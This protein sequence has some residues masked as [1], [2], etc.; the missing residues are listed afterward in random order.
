MTIPTDFSDNLDRIGP[1]NHET[2]NHYLPGSDEA[3]VARGVWSN[4]QLSKC[5][6]SGIQTCMIA[7][8]IVA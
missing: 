3:T 4:H 6:S 2:P 8:Q 1:T 5:H 7:A